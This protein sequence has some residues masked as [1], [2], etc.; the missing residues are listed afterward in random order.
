MRARRVRLAAVLA[1]CALGVVDAVLASGESLTG[2]QLFVRHCAR[3]HTT[4]GSGL[5]A[6]HPLLDNFPNPPADFTDPLFN[7]MEPA[8]DWFL[9]VKHGGASMGL[10]P[11]MPAHVGRMSDPEIEAVVA[12]LASFADTTGYPPGELNFT[13]AVRTIKAFPE[14]E[15]LFLQR[16][17]SAREE[18]PGARLSTLYYAHRLGPRFQVEAKLN[19]LDEG[20]ISDVHEAELGVKWAFYHRNT[21]LILAAGTDVEIP[22][23]T[24]KETTFVPY[25]SHALPLGERFTLQGTL[26]THLPVNELSAGDVEL[27][28]VV[29][30]LPTEWPRGVFPG[31]E[32]TL[33]APFEADRDW[34]AS[35]IP[36]LH[37]AL[38]KRGH[39]ALNVGLEAPIAGARDD[40]R[41]RL[42]TFLLWDIADGPFWLGW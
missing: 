25:L 34:R 35:V 12:Y 10:A 37:F 20:A 28:E 16:Y 3:C 42:H 9:V 8:G 32:V 5:P 27:S 21:D 13:R 23:H 26:R 30:W 40:Y 15:L 41:Y 38:T 1:L 39:V 18:D 14:T 19:Y 11:Q 36:Q 17:E 29:H 2:E 24:A 33:T 7:S 6:R 22:V 31:L 4:A